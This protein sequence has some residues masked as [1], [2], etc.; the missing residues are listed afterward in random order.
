MCSAFTTIFFYVMQYTIFMLMIL[1]TNFLFE[2]VGLDRNTFS[3]CLTFPWNLLKLILF[4]FC[5]AS[6]SPFLFSSM[7]ESTCLK[8]HKHLSDLLFGLPR[9]FAGHCPVYL[10]SSPDNSDAHKRLRSTVLESRLYLLSLPISS[11]LPCPLGSL[12]TSYVSTATCYFCK[13]SQP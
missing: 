4:S 1:G 5:W 2:L 13:C 6:S 7:T 8:F 10:T 11:V 9:D 3:A 12:P